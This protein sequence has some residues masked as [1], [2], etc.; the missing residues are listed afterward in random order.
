MGSKLSSR[1][2]G[3]WAVFNNGLGQILGLSC[4]YLYTKVNSKIGVRPFKN[5]APGFE[6]QNPK[7]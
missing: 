7:M 4:L 2:F 6:M 3:L 5:T 1:N